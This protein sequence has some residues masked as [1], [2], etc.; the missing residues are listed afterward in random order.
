MI[1]A[2]SP[3]QQDFLMPDALRPESNTTADQP[4]NRDNENENESAVNLD[5]LDLENAP[6]SISFE[7]PSPAE[8]M[9]VSSPK[10]KGKSRDLGQPGPG[11]GEA[12]CPDIPFDPALLDTLSKELFGE[13]WD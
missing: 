2:A 11:D 1:T 13:A 7:N 3:A 6:N 5:F 12:G 9:Q 10:D 8:G 4:S